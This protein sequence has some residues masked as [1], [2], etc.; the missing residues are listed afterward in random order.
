MLTIVFAFILI[1]LL[2]VG[3]IDFKTQKISNKWI[4]INLLTSVVLYVAFSESYP[5]SWEVLIFPAGFIFV[6][7]FLYLINVM[8]AGDSKYL[9][10]LFL[11]VPL[12]LHLVLFE[13]IVVTTICTGAFLLI[14]RIILNR[15]DFKAFIFSHH[16]EGVRQI[17]KS[18]FSYAPVILLA[19]FF[20]GLHIWK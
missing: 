18:R 13:K 16:W 14:Y 12:D 5:L 20:L 11:M 9:S 2:I 3:W 4:L 8:G 10:S 6:G 7:F 1:E 17:L 15:N 19:W